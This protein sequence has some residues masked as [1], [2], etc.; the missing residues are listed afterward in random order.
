MKTKMLRLAISLIAVFGLHLSISAQTLLWEDFSNATMPPAGWSIQGLNAQWSVSGS[1]L[2]GGSAP[3][4]KFTYINQT[5]STRLI[6]PVINTT[7]LTSL[8]ISFRHFYDDY[9]GAGPKAGVATH[10]GNGSWT[11]VWEINP[12][13]NVGPEQVSITV[14]NSD[15]GKPDFQFCFYL[16]GNM[17]NIDY[18][19]IDNVLC[20]NPLQ[21]DGFMISLQNT[22]SYFGGPSPVKGTIMN[23]GVDN[24]TSL[25]INWQL[26]DGTPVSSQFSGLN[27]PTLGTYD[28]TTVELMNPPVGEYQLKAW[29]NKV[30]GAPDNNAAN[31]TA[32]TSVQRASLVINR[33]PLFEEFTSSTCNPCASFNTSF[34]PW[35]QQHENDITLIKYQM[36]WPGSGDP[37]YTPEGG[38]R[39]TYY[40]VGFVPDLYVNGAQTATDIGAVNAAFNSAIQQPG[41]L[42]IIGKHTISNKIISGDVTVLPF[43]HFT[44]VRL[45]VVVMEK[46]TH[47]NATTNGETSFHHVMMKMIPDANGTSLELFDRIPYTYNYTMD[48]SGTHIEEFDDLIVGIFV[49][50]YDRKDVYQ[51]NYSTENGVFNNDATLTDLQVDG[52]TIAGFDPSTLSYDY[53]LDPGTTSVPLVT[54]IPTDMNATVIII[55]ALELPGTS[56]IDVFGEDLLSHNQYSVNF[57]MSGVGVDEPTANIT[58]QPNPAK[59]FI[60]IANAGNAVVRIMSPDGKV[61][62]SETNV[63]NRTINLQNLVP[64]T[65]IV[66]IEKENGQIIRKKVV[67]VR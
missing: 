35:T 60:T 54:A 17:Y 65:Y 11:S 9:S 55:P 49:Q 62:I 46:V 56:T 30:N 31:D 32:V 13:G 19:Y 1:S 20:L 59:D 23:T 67:V 2:A 34:N 40:G 5:T 14:T 24:I 6:S 48:L 33:R 58:L 26:N 25:E 47:N 8:K 27:I 21:V 22:P 37:Y 61:L 66:S 38:V 18:W 63:N 10:S 29:I 28:F 52:T 36:N 45:Y 15:V 7:G 57:Y 50:Q 51:S 4:A 53:R 43:A 16:D 42:K 44:G 12:S 39:K 64:G 41:V 3:E